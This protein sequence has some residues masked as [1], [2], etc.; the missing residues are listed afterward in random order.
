MKKVICLY[1][2]FFILSKSF[3]L[4]CNIGFL[5]NVISSV[6]LMRDLH[7]VHLFMRLFLED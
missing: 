7:G 5:V 2:S 4:T 1:L 3:Y 6:N